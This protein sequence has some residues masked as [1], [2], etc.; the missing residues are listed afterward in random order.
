MLSF[1]SVILR[2]KKTVVLAAVAGF[3]LS[4]RHQPC[5]AGKIFTRWAP[6]SPEGVEQ[7]LAGTNS[8]LS[9][10]GRVQ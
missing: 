5:P 6:S 2:K 8:F 1:L 4:S 7:E 9:R 3:I 10:L